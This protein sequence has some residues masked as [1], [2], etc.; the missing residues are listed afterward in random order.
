M[1][2][3]RKSLHDYAWFFIYSYQMAQ[4]SNN[5]SFHP[6]TKRTPFQDITN[7]SSTGEV[8][9]YLH[10]HPGASWFQL[11]VNMQRMRNRPGHQFNSS[12]HK[13]WRYFAGWSTYPKKAERSGMVWPN[14]WRTKS[15]V[16]TQTTWNLTTKTSC[17]W[18][19][20]EYAQTYPALEP[21]GIKTVFT[22]PM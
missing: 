20:K 5:S 12:A 9:I 15:W 4:K 14:D 21:P 18:L 16:P 2:T 13:C 8:M 11:I 1:Y 3:V 17:C 19:H 7:T 6:A 10:L 22:I